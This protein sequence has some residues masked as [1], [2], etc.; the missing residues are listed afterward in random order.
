MRVLRAVI[1]SIGMMGLAT[2]CG[3]GS[4]AAEEPVANPC[5]G[6]PCAAN[7]CN[8]CAGG[9]ENPC[10]GDENPC[11]GDENPCGGDENPCEGGD[12]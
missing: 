9:D 7:P 11:G 6:N 4:K 12:W 1:L 5:A 3:G 2:A 8:P 10:G